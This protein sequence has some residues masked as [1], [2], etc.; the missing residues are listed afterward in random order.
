MKKSKPE[1]KEAVLYEALYQAVM[2]LRDSIAHAFDDLYH[3]RDEDRVINENTRLSDVLEW[4]ESVVYDY[5]VNQA[6]SDVVDGM[7]L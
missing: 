7:D 5:E 1:T 4:A 2:P 6:I 3:V